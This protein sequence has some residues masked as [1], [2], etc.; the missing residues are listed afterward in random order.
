VGKYASIRYHQGR[1]RRSKLALS[2]YYGGLRWYISLQVNYFCPRLIL[3]PA[4]G[5][6]R[7]AVLA[8]NALPEDYSGELT[9]VLNDHA[10]HVVNRNLLLLS[11]L[12]T[13][14]DTSFGVDV[15]LHM[16]YSAFVPEAYH[17]LAIKHIHDLLS[18][19]E[20]GDGAFS[21]NL[22]K[23]SNLHGILGQGHA[24]LLL[25]SFFSQYTLADANE[26]IQ[27]VQ[28]VHLPSTNNPND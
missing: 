26:E 14:D 22:G 3:W 18:R 4:S 13:S 7:N 10:P 21:L 11:I 2:R 1:Q 16:W 6:L 17:L 25:G 20:T 28:Y 23:T 24:E 5:D 12:G 15:A 19:R 8:V 9:I 27:R